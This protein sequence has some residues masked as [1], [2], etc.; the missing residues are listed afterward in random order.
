M[1]KT[2]APSGYYTAK[3]AMDRLNMGSSTFYKFVKDHSIEREIPPN[4][5]EGF[6]KKS[7]IDQIAQQNALFVLTH[8]I[9]P[10]TFHRVEN[11]EDIKG[12]VDLCISIYG[13]GGT[14]N[15]DAR[16]E[17]WE[18]NPEVYYIVKQ[19]GIVSGYASLIE[20]DAEAIAILMGP[21]PKQRHISSAG[22]GV[23][24]ITGPEH[25]MPFIEGKPIDHLFISLGVRP[26]FTTTEQRTYSFVLLRGIVD[27]LISFAQRGMPVKQLYATSERI[28]GIRLARKFGMKEIRYQGDSLLRYE[29]DVAHSNN[30][31][32][33]P[34]R[35]VLAEY[36]DQP[37][38]D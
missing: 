30:I 7:I 10:V 18:V 36:Q 19:E 16:R 24:S 26:G 5:K 8:S 3:E 31:L 15:F 34:Y 6:Y 14:P 11:D 23:Y 9:E 22:A 21:T 20:F 35:K 32:L 17:I 33:R 25:V 28:E 2:K 38:R 29:M 1:K 27:A 4:K 37:G 13:Q 12:I